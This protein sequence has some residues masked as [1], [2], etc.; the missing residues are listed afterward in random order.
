MLPVKELFRLKYAI[1]VIV[2]CLGVFTYAGLSGWRFIGSDAT[3]WEKE[4]LQKSGTTHHRT[5]TTRTGIYH[6]Y[7]K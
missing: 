2:I 1:V 4:G 3:A 6:R 7:H 5:H